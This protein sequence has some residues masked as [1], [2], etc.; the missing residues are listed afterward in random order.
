MTGRRFEGHTCGAKIPTQA[1]TGLA[2]GTQ[3][4]WGGPPAKGNRRGGEYEGHVGM[5]I[6]QNRERNWGN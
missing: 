3:H 6:D 2:W 5:R 4:G 1:K